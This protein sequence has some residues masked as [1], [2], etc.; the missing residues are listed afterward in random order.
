[1]IRVGI[2]VGG[3]FTDLA[4]VDVDTGERVALKVPS[5]P[6]A[7]ERAVLDAL[8]SLARLDVEFLGHSTTVATNALLGQIGLELPR[9]ALVTTHGFRDVIEIGRQ[10][11]SEI[12]NLFV[13][14]PRPL[15]ARDDRLTVHER[16]GS[17]GEILEPLDETS[18]ERVCTELQARK[19]V[20]AVA[21]CLLN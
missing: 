8:S 18:L 4:A 9:V 17:N 21:I 13:T 12:Y 5:T 19:D 20:A 16:V 11:R 7:P 14:R 15:V 10:S 1:M 2:D 6:H 3:T